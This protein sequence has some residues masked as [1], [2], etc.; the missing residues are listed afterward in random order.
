[1]SL[2]TLADKAVARL[3]SFDKMPFRIGWPVPRT[4]QVPAVCL[5]RE[6]KGHRNRWL[7]WVLFSSRNVI[8]SILEIGASNVAVGESDGVPANFLNVCKSVRLSGSLCSN[9]GRWNE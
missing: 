5:V 6:P 8:C 2:R 4:T 7:Y 3:C 1:M 9:I